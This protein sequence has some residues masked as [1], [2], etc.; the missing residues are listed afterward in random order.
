MEKEIIEKIIDLNDINSGEIIKSLKDDITKKFGKWFNINN[1]TG[2]LIITN[3][4]CI[5]ILIEGY[6]KCCENWGYE[7]CKNS[8]IIETQDDLK[9]F[10]GSEVLSIER[11]TTENHKS[12]QIYDK[13]EE[14]LKNDCFYYPDT[15]F[16]SIKTSNGI[17]Q[18]AVYNSHNGYYGH[19]IY[20]VF[21]QTIIQ[22]TL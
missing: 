15:E 6:Q 3:K 22:D 17:L 7:A 1:Y 4:Q 20:I 14:K 16:V 12:I 19:N 8:G 9:D 2:F 13:L 5:Y 10:I 11:I 18:F 21:N